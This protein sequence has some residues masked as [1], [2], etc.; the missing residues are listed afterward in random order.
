[1]A[2][3]IQ[4]YTRVNGCDSNYNLSLT[5]LSANDSVIAQGANLHAFVSGAIY[6][7]LECP[8]MQPVVGAV[9]QNFSPTKNGDYALAIEDLGCKDTSICFTVTDVGRGNEEMPFVE[10]FPNPASDVLHIRL[11]KDQ[12]D[13]AMEILDVTGKITKANMLES[14]NDIIFN[15]GSLTRVCI[16]FE[17]S[18]KTEVLFINGLRSNKPIIVNPLC[19]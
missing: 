8:S 4:H 5:L 14:S 19:F 7:W 16:I 1:V 12:S 15:I 18:I 10:I 3:I 6:Q 13:V 2:P 9:F 17:L 11:D